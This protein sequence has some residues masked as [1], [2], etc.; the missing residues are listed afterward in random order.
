MI[1]FPCN[2]VFAIQLFCCVCSLSNDS[3][4]ME[5]VA[6]NSDNL[7]VLIL[8]GNSLGQQLAF[9]AYLLMTD[10]CKLSHLS[11]RRTDLQWFQTHQKVEWNGISP[12]KRFTSVPLLFTALTQNTSSLTLNIGDNYLGSNVCYSHAPSDRSIYWLARTLMVNC[13]LQTLLICDNCWDEVDVQLLCCSPSTAVG[14]DLV[15]EV[16]SWLTDWHAHLGCVPTNSLLHLRTY[17][18]TLSNASIAIEYW[19]SLDEGLERR[20]TRLTPWL[21]GNT[22]NWVSSKFHISSRCPWLHESKS[23]KEQV[24]ELFLPFA[25]KLMLD[26][27]DH[28]QRQLLFVAIKYSLSECSMASCEL[29]D[30]DATIIASSLYAATNLKILHLNHNHIG[31]NGAYQLAQIL[32][33]NTS[34]EQLDLCHNDLLLEAGGGVDALL[35]PCVSMRPY[36]I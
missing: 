26:S 30:E 36:S 22:V 2:V 6:C 23:P 24:L 29:T 15:S 33:L 12:E 16:P 28:R 3:L 13:T 4:V 31:P 7:S 35:T 17:L 21:Q 19:I 20:D 10:S 5:C 25:T 11:L 1:P 18:K 8:D 34:L 32:A 9:I 27:C 14:L